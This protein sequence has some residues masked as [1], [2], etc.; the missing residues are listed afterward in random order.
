MPLTQQLFMMLILVMTSKGIAAVPSGSLVV[1]LATA[2]AVGLPAE[3]VAI[4]A[5]VDRIM[6]MARTGV[7][8]PGHAIACIVVS[9]W[10]KVFRTQTPIPPGSHT[11]SL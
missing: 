4:I 5:G 8:V 2:N 10:E 9:K 7:N 3:G 6:D 1:L 11:E